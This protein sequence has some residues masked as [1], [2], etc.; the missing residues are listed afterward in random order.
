MLCVPTLTDCIVGIQSKSFPG[1]VP[2]TQVNKLTPGRGLKRSLGE[3]S[4]G[5]R[6][7]NIQKETQRE[8]E[9]QEISRGKETGHKIEVI[10]AMLRPKAVHSS[11][12]NVN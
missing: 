7:K 10:I 5:P 4:D 8:R 12:E 1:C 6:A 2:E 11:G 9:S 3:D